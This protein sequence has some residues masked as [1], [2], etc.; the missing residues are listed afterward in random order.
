MLTI[1]AM[2]LLL[3]IISKLDIT[4]IIDKLKTVDIFKET[5]SK[6]DALAQ[7][8]KEAVGTLAM[9]ILADITPQLGRV[10]D[11][12]PPLVAAYKNI[13]IDEAETLDSA[14]VINEIIHDEGITTFFKRALRKKVEQSA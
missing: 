4:P 12:I 5:D 2:P 3:K 7:L 1:K 13:S 8:D 11:D 14:E 9:E 10:A 6:E